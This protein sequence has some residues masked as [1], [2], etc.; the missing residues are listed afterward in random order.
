MYVPI[1]FDASA[2]IVD[3]ATLVHY[4]SVLEIARACVIL[5][6]NVLNKSRVAVHASFA[7]LSTWDFSYFEHNMAEDTCTRGYSHCFNILALAASSRVFFTD[8]KHKL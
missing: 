8:R 3:V 4:L 2:V 7:L 1:R 5:R 6:I